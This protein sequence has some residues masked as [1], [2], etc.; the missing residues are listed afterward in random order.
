MKYIVTFTVA[1][2]ISGISYAQSLYSFD[3]TMSFGSGET[4]DYIQSLGV[5]AVWLSP[6]FPSPMH[7]F[8]YDVADYVGINT[9]FGTMND[10]DALLDDIHSRG[11][12]LILDHPHFFIAS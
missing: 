1:L 8:G 4:A 10:F 6:I 12:K 3:Y 2:L 11:M 5:E 7:D 9:M